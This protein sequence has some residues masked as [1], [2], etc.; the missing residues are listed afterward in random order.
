MLHKHHP[1][2]VAASIGCYGACLADG[3]EFTGDYDLSTEELMD[4]HRPRCQALASASPDLFAFETI[5]SACEAVACAQLLWEFPD[6]PAWISM[7]CKSEHEL[8]RGD[9]MCE[10][11]EQIEKICPPNLIAIGINCTKPQYIS[12]LIRDI[13]QVSTRLIVVYPNKGELWDSGS[14]T[15]IPGIHNS[16]QI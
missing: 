11:I 12:S 7:S 2:F 3:S 16:L 1:M 4:F 9:S 6:I 5:P 13:K 15:W 14:R 8:N 10:T